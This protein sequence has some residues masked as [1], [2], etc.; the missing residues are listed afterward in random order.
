MYDIVITNNKQTIK[1]KEDIVDKE[2]TK[3]MYIYLPASVHEA[4]R[5]LAF[6][7]RQG[8]S[9]II[10]DLILKD[11]RIIREL[12]KKKAEPAVNEA[13]PTAQEKTG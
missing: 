4:L 9:T 8:M 13:E 11:E 6:D 2:K 3:P 7:T 12:G 10:R 5:Q 1:I